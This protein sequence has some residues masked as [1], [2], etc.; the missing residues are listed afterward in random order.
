MY[1]KYKFQLK[2]DDREIIKKRLSTFPNILLFEERLRLFQ[3]FAI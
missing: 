2:I 3:Y 1:K